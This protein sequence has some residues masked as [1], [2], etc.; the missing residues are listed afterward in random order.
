MRILE[1]EFVER[2]ITYRQIKREGKVAVYS[3][4]WAGEPDRVRGYEVFV[5]QSHGDVEIYGN[6]VEAAET[7]PGKNAFG[8]T[9]WSYVKLEKALDRMSQVV[10][11][12]GMKAEKRAV[13]AQSL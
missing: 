11:A 12:E 9:A 6:K 3:H 7:Y 2:N 10:Q 5:I 4:S 13:K 1:T 8:K